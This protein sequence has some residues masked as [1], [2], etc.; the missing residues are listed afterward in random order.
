MP[1]KKLDDGSTY[2]KAVHHGETTMRGTWEVSIKIDGV[3]MFKRDGKALSR[4]SIEYPN[5]NLALLDFTDA[6]YFSGDWG[7][8]MGDTARHNAVV[9]QDF[10][11]NLDPLD[12]R[13]RTD[14]VLV[15]PTEEE[16]YA[17]MQKFVDQGYE[18]IVIRNRDNGKW[19]KV[20]PI[21]SADIRITGYTMS[22]KRVG[23]IKSFITNHGNISST[24]FKEEQLKEIAENGPESY[25]GKIAEV[26]YREV[27]KETGKLR[28]AAFNRW[29]TD[30]TEESLT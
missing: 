12:Y 30:K 27:F 11:Y 29:R 4:A 9:N 8:S 5:K 10:V 18:G 25:I 17:C 7:K 1:I 20:V 28:F 2:N 16:R 6:E 26:D 3:R 21:K 23:W 22:D 19:V 13:L 24:G 15:N 14:Y